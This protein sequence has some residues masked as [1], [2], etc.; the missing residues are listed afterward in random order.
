MRQVLTATGKLTEDAV[1]PAARESLLHAFRSWKAGG[2]SG[3]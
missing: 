1:D 3:T 2:G